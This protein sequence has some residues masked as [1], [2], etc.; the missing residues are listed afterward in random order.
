VLVAAGA[1][2]G[3]FLLRTW[4]ETTHAP[5]EMSAYAVSAPTEMS[6]DSPSA[7]TGPIKPVPAPNVAANPASSAMVAT[8]HLRVSTKLAPGELQQIEAALAKAGYQNVVVHEMPFSISRS[9]VGYFQ[10]ADRT[11][12]EALIAALRGTLDGVELRDY[13]KL[14]PTSETSRLDLWV[15]G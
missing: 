15:K 13:R 6:G 14:I 3:G 4:I 10:E 2:V 9:R 5:S 8:V 7:P 1:V 11:A 12:A